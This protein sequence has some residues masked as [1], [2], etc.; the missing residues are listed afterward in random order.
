MCMG[1]QVTKLLI[2]WEIIPVKVLIIDE[3]LMIGR[4]TFPNVDLALVSIGWI[5]LLFVDFLQLLPVNQ[6]GVLM[7][8]K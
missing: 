3:I 7:K 5:S 8:I 1:S 2:F 6:K 4:E